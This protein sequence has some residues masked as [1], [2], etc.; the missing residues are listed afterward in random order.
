MI[1]ALVIA[2]AVAPAVIALSPTVPAIAGTVRAY[3]V[4][5][6]R[7]QPDYT[8]IEYTAQAGER[9]QLAVS[10]AGLDVAVGD[11]AQIEPGPGCRRPSGLD[12]R[13]AV[14]SMIAGGRLRAKLGDE[15]DEATSYLPERSLLT[16]LDLDGDAGN[17]TLL[18]GPESVD[19]LTGG[20]GDDELLGGAGSDFFR[21]GPQASGSDVLRGGPGFDHVLYAGRRRDVAADPDGDRDDGEVGENDR[22]S[23]DV[24]ALSGGSGNDR[25]STV[26]ARGLRAGDVPSPVW[27]AELYGGRGNDRLVGQA[28]R[29]RLYGDAGAD[30]LDGAGGSDD[31]DGE[32]GNDR[33][34]GGTGDDGLAGGAG[35]D[36]LDGELG[37]DV[38]FGDEGDDRL[39]GGPGLDKLF[40]DLNGPAGDDRLSGG[41]GADLLEDAFGRDRFSGGP[42]SDRINSRDLT[43]RG[44]RRRDRITCGA[45]RRDRAFVVEQTAFPPPASECDDARAGGPLNLR[46]RSQGGPRC[47][48]VALRQGWETPSRSRHAVREPAAAATKAP[49]HSYHE[50]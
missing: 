29:E 1:R 14:C 50:E 38:L 27:D 4:P 11:S 37:S 34:R 18:G 10:I 42:Q 41:G 46:V 40:G 22:I 45:G 28:A 44:R 20:P 48:G 31:L 15:D 25:L 9:N 19:S 5:A 8:Q 6:P 13:I 12:P 17:D 36:R 49:R 33:L 26:G 32:A 7:G 35:D 16:E 21:E 47:E 43:P 30:F 39:R 3:T 2:V 23:S 24:E